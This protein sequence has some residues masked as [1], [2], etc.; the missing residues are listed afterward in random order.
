MSYFLWNSMPDEPLFTAA[1]MGS[2]GTDAALSSQVQRMLADPKA[3]TTIASFHRQWLDVEDVGDQLKDPAMFPAFG[4][5][6]TDAMTQSC[7]CSR[8]TSS[9]RETD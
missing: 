8:T 9:S 2:L 4:A 7:R 1:A 6:L 5:T 3:T